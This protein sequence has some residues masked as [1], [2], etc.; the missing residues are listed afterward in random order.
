[1]EAL[2]ETVIYLADEAGAEDVFLEKPAGSAERHG[3]HLVQLGFNRRRICG[4]SFA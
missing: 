3:R 4:T 2:A 1:V